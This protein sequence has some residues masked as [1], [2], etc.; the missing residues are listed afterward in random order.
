MEKPLHLLIPVDFTEVTELSL[1]YAI[2]FAREVW[3]KI[4]L[5]HII[6]NKISFINKSNFENKLIE[7]KTLKRLQNLADDIQKDYRIATEIIVLPGN[8]FDTINQVVKELEI[9]Y[10][11]MGTHGRKGFNFLKGSNALRVIHQARVPY[12]LTQ[13]NSLEYNGFREIVFPIDISDISILKVENALFMWKHFRSRIKIFYPQENQNSSIEK[14][15]KHLTFVKKF[16]STNN[17][18]YTVKRSHRSAPDFFDEVPEYAHEI[19]ADLIMTMVNPERGA[20]EFLL[21]THT[22]EIITNRH[23]IP[24]MCINNLAIRNKKIVL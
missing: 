19:R 13:R 21:T 2:H 23:R 15:N 5:L 18:E 1:C 22:Q 24:V 4:H 20:G 11:F 10:V 6:E 8:I 17:V 9:D 7:E 16:F 12:I 3:A 14:V